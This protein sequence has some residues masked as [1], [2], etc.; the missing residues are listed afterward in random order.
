VKE[1][2]VRIL[3]RIG[4]PIDQPLIASAAVVMEG[5]SKMTAA[6]GDIEAIMDESLNDIRRVTGMILQKKIELF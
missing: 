2:Y 4:K 5:R 1:A 6:K 3:S